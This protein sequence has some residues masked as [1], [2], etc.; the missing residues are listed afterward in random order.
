MLILRLWGGSDR[1]LEWFFT[2]LKFDK[3]CVLFW[4]FDVVNCSVLVISVYETLCHILQ[5]YL[6]ANVYKQG[7]LFWSPSALPSSGNLGTV[8][9]KPPSSFANWSTCRNHSYSPKYTD[10][11]HGIMEIIWQNKNNTDTY[12]VYVYS[13]WSNIYRCSFDF[14]Q[15][16][17]W[18]AVVPTRL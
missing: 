2:V 18:F 10:W 11:V 3:S 12:Q 15:N 14:E 16:S 8:H 1:I 9:S 6:G 17:K 5:L 7:Q 13:I 4:H